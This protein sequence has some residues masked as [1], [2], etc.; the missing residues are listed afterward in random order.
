[1]DSK[2]RCYAYNELDKDLLRQFSEGSAALESLLNF[3]YQNQVETKA[4][5]A[6][7]EKEGTHKTPYIAFVVPQSQNYVF[8]NMFNDIFQNSEFGKCI[9]FE[10]GQIEDL[11][12]VTCRFNYFGNELR[13]KLFNL[14][15]YSM[16]NS[17]INNVNNPGIYNGLLDVYNKLDNENL[18]LEIN[19]N[20]VEFE[21][22]REA[23]GKE[24]NGEVYEVPMEE[25][26]F[27]YFVTDGTSFKNNDELEQFISE[28]Q[29]EFGNS[30]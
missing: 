7:H 20:G 3:C 28:K 24:V 12:Q 19:P 14:I 21:L 8:E 22:R 25:A 5:C 17:I 4:C 27:S 16:T 11:I 30:K 9:N 13:E 2:V 29:S 1:M 15:Q 23:Y 26:E 18:R 6:G 10:I